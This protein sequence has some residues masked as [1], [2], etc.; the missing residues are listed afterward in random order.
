MK[1]AAEELDE[2]GADQLAAAAAGPG[3]AARIVLVNGAV[4]DLRAGR[5]ESRSGAGGFGHG[6]PR[7]CTRAAAFLSK[8]RGDLL[9]RKRCVKVHALPRFAAQ[10]PQRFGLPVGFNALG[11]DAQAAGFT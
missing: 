4:L 6:H 9:R 2:L 10:G 5:P 8:Q 1:P 11:R 3:P 7:N